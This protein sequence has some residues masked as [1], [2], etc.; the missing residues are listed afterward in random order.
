MIDKKRI[1][2]EAKHFF[3]WPTDD[4][5]YVTR[6]SMLIFAN[7]IA[8]MVRKELEI[9]ALKAQPVQPAPLTDADIQTAITSAVKAGELSWLGFDVDADGRFTIP[10]VST[11]HYQLARA[12][13]NLRTGGAG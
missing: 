10:V 6:T 9:E 13:W 1:E 5:S 8:E 7:T 3:A 12:I 11:C 2:E 4:R